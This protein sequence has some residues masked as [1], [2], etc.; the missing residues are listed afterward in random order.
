MDTGNHRS[1]TALRHL[2]GQLDPDESEVQEQM[3]RLKKIIADGG[4]TPADEVY[5]GVPEVMDFGTLLELAVFEPKEADL[6][7]PARLLALHSAWP[8]L[9]AAVAM[10]TRRSR[11]LM[12]D[13]LA[14]HVDGWSCRL[15]T[16]S[17]TPDERERLLR[18]LRVHVDDETSASVRTVAPLWPRILGGLACAL[19]G[20][21][22][23]LWQQGGV[24]GVVIAVSLFVL[25]YAVWGVVSVPVRRL[26]IRQDGA[27]RR[28]RAAD[29]LTAAFD[30]H[31]ALM[32]QW[33]SGLATAARFGSWSPSP[34][35]G[36]VPRQADAP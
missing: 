13:H 16:S 34:G 36:S 15:P 22:L 12:P 17:D 21:L 19:L 28:S 23:G 29:D 27:R 30:Q 20:V 8:S 9:R 11:S 3:R 4:R 14:L 18:E 5:G 32:H 33:Q 6:E 10:V 1:D 24:G 31:D 35:Y 26:L 7:Y 25:L 2:I